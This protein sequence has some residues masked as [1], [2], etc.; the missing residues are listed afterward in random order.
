MLLDSDNEDDFVS[1]CNINF[2][3]Q[4]CMYMQIAN[5]FLHSRHRLCTFYVRGVYN[6]KYRP[7]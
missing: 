5:L 4:I 1:R 2:M 7:K 6:V 3:A